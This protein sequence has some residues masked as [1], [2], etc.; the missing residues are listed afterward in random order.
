MRFF[1]EMKINS[2]AWA[3]RFSY[4]LAKLGGKDAIQDRTPKARNK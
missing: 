1:I 2:F 4:I 3:I